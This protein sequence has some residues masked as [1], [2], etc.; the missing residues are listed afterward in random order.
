[1]G[2][3][4]FESAT[5]RRQPGSPTHLSVRQLDHTLRGATTVVT[6]TKATRVADRRG[7]RSSIG[8]AGPVL[9]GS[10]TSNGGAKGRRGRGGDAD[11]GGGGSVLSSRRSRR[12]RGKDR[13]DLRG[14]GEASRPRDQVGARHGRLLGE[15]RAWWDL[16]GGRLS[17]S[18]GLVVKEVK[19]SRIEKGLV[20]CSSSKISGT[21]I[22]VCYTEWGERRRKVHGFRDRAR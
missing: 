20:V 3:N 13:A 12:G 18:K 14:D 5:S 11:R 22:V 19:S 9:R 15:E 8:G 16:V 21:G 7:R 6:P 17:S 10:T 4:D 2:Q 1:M